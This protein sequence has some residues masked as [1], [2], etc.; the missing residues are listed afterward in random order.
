MQ[1]S[2]YALI[3]ILLI[4]C[5]GNATAINASQI[6]VGGYAFK[7][8]SWWEEIEIDL[9][10]T[11]SVLTHDQMSDYIS[12]KYGS[13][14]GNADT[15]KHVLKT[16]VAFWKENP[17][18]AEMPVYIGHCL[19]AGGKHKEAASVYVALCKMANDLDD[20]DREWFLCYL[21]Y[22]AGECYAEIDEIQKA[23]QW[24]EFSSS[25]SSS[26]NSGVKFYAEQSSKHLDELKKE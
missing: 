13:D 17:R 9:P 10:E 25:F 8:P 11:A 16:Y 18:E 15:W 14:T 20:E 3:L 21:S 12:K 23:I 19:K 26:S 6:E 5:I 24:F 2:K 22:S 1:K 7:T 4:L